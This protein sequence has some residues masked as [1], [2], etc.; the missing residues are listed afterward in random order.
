MRVPYSWLKELVPAAPGVEETAGLLTSIGL[1]V[2][3][4]HELAAAPG[5]VV[6]EI[7]AVEAIEGSDHLVLATVMDGSKEYAVVCGAPNA[8][9][10]VRTALALPGTHLPGAGFDVE[11]REVMGVRSEGV[12]CSP[13]ELDLYDYAG[14]IM[15]FGQDA[16]PGTPL[17]ELWPEE[18]VLELE[19][20]PNR[21]DAFSV[22]G[23]A[24]DLAAKLD[25]EY[26]HPAYVH[27]A[28][29]HP[30]YEHPADRAGTPEDDG[31]AIEIA[32]PEACP[33]FTLQ[34]ITGVRIGPSP[35]WMQRRLAALGLRPRNNVVDATNYVTFE[36]GQ[37]SH[38]YDRRVL[39][40]GTI[41]VRR[42]EPGERLTTLGEDELELTTEDLVIATPSD[43][44][45]RAIGLA[46][47]IGGLRDSI[48]TQTTDVALE[49]AHFDPVT[50]RKTAKRHGLSTDAHYRFERGVDPSL[51]PRASARAAA[52]IAEV[53]GGVVHPD[54]TDRGSAPAVAEVHFR[55]ARVEFLMAVDI[56]EDRQKRY[57]EALGCDVDTDGDAWRV[58]VPSWRFDLAIEEDLIEE[59][60]RLH[61]FE[62]I[63]ESVPAMHFVPPRTD[64]THRELRELL[65][66]AGLQ[67]TMGYVFTSD[68]ELERA[69]AP[70]AKVRLEHP[71]GTERSVLRTAL[72]PGLLQ[73]AA[74][75]RNAS[76]L[77]LFEVGRVFLE[78][79]AERVGMV[80]RGPWTDDLLHERR[81]LDFFVVKGLLE[82]IGRRLRAKLELRPGQGSHLHPGVAADVHWNGRPIGTAGRL[83]PEIAASYELS[84]ETYL[85]E[86]D[87]PLAAQPL[88]FRD[89][90]RQPWAERDLAI[91]APTDTTYRDL[92]E[93]AKDAAGDKLASLEPFDVYEGAPI[94]AG[95]RSVALRLRFRDP[96]RSL[97]DEEV[98]GYMAN[99]IEA[100]RRRGYAIRE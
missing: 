55:P 71:Q 11:V 10:G 85:V 38:A 75:N 54:F 76:S 20:T 12:L 26:V 27:P 82:A 99:V 65:A 41:Q 23:V 94:P 77:A 96:A 91:M 47:V 69:G 92:A 17:A 15:A 73:A 66:G 35:V 34:L 79:E 49:V 13:K 70:P 48:G 83:H 51:P 89:V 59:V 80:F 78:Q 46:G 72:H 57:L 8:R 4:V 28:Y 42:A 40:D 88:R 39:R 56:P 18:S 52:L 29:E 25:T 50:I 67:E 98:D 93:L 16:E 81:E 3:Q 14:G 30:A 45:S 19:L 68:D 60:A 90:V 97:T 32:D 31:L 58:R 100:V 86:L 33:R 2:E 7:T 61:G 43:D 84:A 64:P 24:R 22:L 37:P 74:T 87:L 36:L 6:A 21:A 95:H 9:A 1:A 44:G 53:A 62:H 5:V 63:G